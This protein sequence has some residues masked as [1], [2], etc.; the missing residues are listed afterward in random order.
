MIGIDSA[1]VLKTLNHNPVMVV[2]VLCYLLVART[3]VFRRYLDFNNLMQEWLEVWENF[4][5]PV[6]M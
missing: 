4:S 6:E 5:R 3:E 2:V 1:T